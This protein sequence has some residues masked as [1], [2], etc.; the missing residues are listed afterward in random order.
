MN[1]TTTRAIKQ[2]AG[3]LLRNGT[4]WLMVVAAGFLTLI[5]LTWN[6]TVSPA[7]LFFSLD[8]VIYVAIILFGVL[9][10]GCAGA[11]LYDRYRMIVKRLGVDE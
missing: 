1:A 11:W 6:G 8:Y 10:L 9:I 4:L 2:L 5:V 3:E 7:W